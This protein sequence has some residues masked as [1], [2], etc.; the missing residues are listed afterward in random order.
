MTSP[1]AVHQLWV[2]LKPW[3]GLNP[4]RARS[5]A[6]PGNDRDVDPTAVDVIAGFEEIAAY[7]AEIDGSAIWD[8]A[9]EDERRVRDTGRVER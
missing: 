8:I 4:T 2:G 9:T 7:P 5:Q 6:P 1:F 3:T